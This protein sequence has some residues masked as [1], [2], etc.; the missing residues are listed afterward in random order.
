MRGASEPFSGVV[1]LS[2]SS[3]IRIEYYRVSS[4]VV[5]S[6]RTAF[7]R[8]EILQAYLEAVDEWA[9][10]VVE[11]IS[12]GLR[13]SRLS[14]ADA[15]RELLE[16]CLLDAI[17]RGPRY[18]TAGLFTDFDLFRTCERA[19]QT[20]ERI[21]LSEML[22]ASLP[23]FVVPERPLPASIPEP[24]YR[25]NP[26]PWDTDREWTVDI[27]TIDVFITKAWRANLRHQK[28]SEV[29]GAILADVA[30]GLDRELDRVRREAETLGALTDGPRELKRIMR[31]LV[32]RYIRQ[33]RPGDIL[34]IE[35]DNGLHEEGRAD[36]Q[37]R[38]RDDVAIGRDLLGLPV[39]PDPGGRPRL[40]KPHVVS[41]V[42][43]RDTQ[44]PLTR[45]Q[46]K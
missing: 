27:D 30:A 36:T 44:R 16:R 34:G 15:V 41:R 29:R 26:P 17:A 45:S 31:R 19:R 23:S 5:D 11:S 14:T 38:V 2:D 39:L 32:L 6:I 24:R 10:A 13:A 1:D 9:P 18:S 20:G 28:P 35:R 33:R 4:D 37:R 40:N 3:G 25:P 43:R 8:T 21:N 22:E 42:S 46:P 12:V 7:N